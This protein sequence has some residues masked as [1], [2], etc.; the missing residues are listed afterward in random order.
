MYR[1]ETQ[2]KVMKARMGEDDGKAVKMGLGVEL[3]FEQL[4][5]DYVIVESNK[6]LL[7]QSLGPA[8]IL[9]CYKRRFIN[10]DGID[11][12]DAQQIGLERCFVIYYWIGAILHKSF[13][14]AKCK[15]S[16]KLAVARTKLL[17]NKKGKN[18]GKHPLPQV[19]GFVDDDD[20]DVNQ[21]IIRQAT[22]KKVLKDVE[23]QHWKA[24][25]ED[26]LVFYYDGAYDEI[27]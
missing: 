22:T 14:G 26:P 24:L 8:A 23:E 10:R 7:S 18:Y 16:L 21:E 17:K 15:T 3:V 4:E 27:N 19:P 11:F 12:L 20:G 1:P 25:E 9:R 5:I 13:K 6:L 2:G